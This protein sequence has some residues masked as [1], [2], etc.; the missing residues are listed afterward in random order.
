M[1][2]EQQKEEKDFAVPGR[3]NWKGGECNSNAE[4]D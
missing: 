3:Q 1:S 4:S 2:E